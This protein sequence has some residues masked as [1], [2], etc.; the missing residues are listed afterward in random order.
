M[1]ENEDEGRTKAREKRADL[2]E[3]GGG[4]AVVRTVGEEHLAALNLI[5]GGLEQYHKRCDGESCDG[6]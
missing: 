4:K 2:I 6:C 5:I 3:S 1:E